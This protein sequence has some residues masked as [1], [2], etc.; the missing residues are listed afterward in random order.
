MTVSDPSGELVSGG[1]SGVVVAVNNH[2]RNTLCD[3]P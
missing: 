2:L 3:F 1:H